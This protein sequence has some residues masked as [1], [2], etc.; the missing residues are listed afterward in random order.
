MRR[1]L[2]VI[3]GL[4]FELRGFGVL[5]LLACFA[6][7]FLT[8]WRARHE[9]LDPNAVFDLAVWLISGGFIGARVVYLVQHRE[10][11][12]HVW[13]V[14]KFWQGGIVFYGCILGGLVGSLIYWARHPFP[15]QPMADA[16]APSLALGSA[17]GRLGCW[18]NGCC[19]GAVC[20]LPWAVCF[21]AGTL[22][23]VHHRDAGLIPPSAPCSLAV[24]P[25]Q[26]YAALD[27][28]ILLGLL[29]WYYPRRRRDGEVMALLM[30][31]YPITRFLIEYLRDDEGA[32]F[33]G[34]TLSQ[35]ISVALLVCGLIAW[36]RLAR[37]PHGRYADRTGV[38]AP[39][40][41][42]P[43]SEV[44]ASASR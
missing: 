7:L 26:L 4:G 20:D 11:V 5:L 32:I 42:T 17:L 29:S 16:V 41:A 37:L 15:F 24:H 34:L 35:N 25:T 33:A 8:A 22:P 10:V 31:A 36:S 43:R 40:K 44:V 14:F 30:V 18:L 39:D 23:W 9:K 28:V 1:V 19:Y 38:A 6:A 2:F 12:Q 27:G 21:P 3:P 13:D